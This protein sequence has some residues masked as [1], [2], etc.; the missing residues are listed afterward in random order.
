MVLPPKFQTHPNVTLLVMAPIVSHKQPTI[1]RDTHINMYIIH[2]NKHIYIYTYSFIA[3]PHPFP[4]EMEISHCQ[5]PLFGVTSP[6]QHLRL[7][8]F[9]HA[10]PATNRVFQVLTWDSVWIGGSLLDPFGWVPKKVPWKKELDP[11]IASRRKHMEISYHE[12]FLGMT[13]MDSNLC[14]W[15]SP[16]A[17]VPL[18][19]LKI[20]RYT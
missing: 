11:A 18:G 14:P 15:R 2:I 8:P 17:D 3:V 13:S 5:R 4:A 1:F 16:V 20:H 9:V 7:M 10:P 6:W 19:I 12:T